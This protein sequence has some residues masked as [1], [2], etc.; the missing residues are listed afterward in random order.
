LIVWLPDV[1]LP[2]DQAP[3]ALQVEE[4]LE[5]QVRSVEPPG[6]TVVGAALNETVGDGDGAGGDPGGGVL[7]PPL[8]AD[9]EPPPQAPSTNSNV[10]THTPPAARI[11]R[12]AVP[13]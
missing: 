10:I 4:L 12:I 6:A 5:D 1:A 7:L 13:P 3:V 9:P 2:P 11:V 8:V